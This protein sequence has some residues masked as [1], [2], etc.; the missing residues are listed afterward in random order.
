MKKVIALEPRCPWR[1]F[2]PSTRGVKPDNVRCQSEKRRSQTNPGVCAQGDISFSKIVFCT[3][4]L[5]N[6]ILNLFV[7]VR[8]PRLMR[9]RNF[10]QVVPQEYRSPMPRKVS[11]T[12]RKA[13]ALKHGSCT[14]GGKRHLRTIV[15]CRSR[16]SIIRNKTAVRS[17]YLRTKDLRASWSSLEQPGLREVGRPACPHSSG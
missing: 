16:T 5:L 14:G 13:F 4:F 8:P 7:W 3:C 17:E 12:K 9:I 10:G 1:G 2:G 11:P 6:Q 15:H